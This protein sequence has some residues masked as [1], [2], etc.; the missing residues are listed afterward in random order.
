MRIVQVT[1]GSGDNFYCENCIRDITI[2][3]ELKRQGAEAVMVPL[4]LPPRLD[5]GDTTRD[6]PL[7]DD[8][9]LLL[10]REG[11]FAE[12]SA[13]AAFAGPRGLFTYPEGRAYME[14]HG[15]AEHM[16]EAVHI[17]WLTG[18]ALVPEKVRRQYFE[19]VLS[20]TDAARPGE[21]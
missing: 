1:P 20:P 16:E 4:Y 8:L 9:R 5:V 2:T 14:R 15:L 18:G 6:A 10:Q 21:V 11:L 13:L 12:P 17:A 19:T 3:K 7:Y